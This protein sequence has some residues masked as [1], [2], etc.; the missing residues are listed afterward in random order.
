M[1]AYSV[2][3]RA[4]YSSVRADRSAI[5]GAQDTKVRFVRVIEPQKYKKKC[6]ELRCLVTLVCTIFCAAPLNGSEIVDRI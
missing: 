6:Q 5:E 3:A 4:G 1:R 2:M